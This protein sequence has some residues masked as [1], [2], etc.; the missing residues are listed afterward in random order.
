MIRA[1]LS[2]YR[3]YFYK[4]TI[5]ESLLQ[6]EGSMMEFQPLWQQKCVQVAAA[7]AKAAAARF[8]Q[9]DVDD[10][11]PIHT[12]YERKVADRA[13]EMPDLLLYHVPS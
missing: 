13:L 12:M 3:H 4:K 7:I 2:K 1:K 8:V 9:D 5:E 10:G 11:L 6:R